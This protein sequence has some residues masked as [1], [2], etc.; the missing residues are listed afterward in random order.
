MQMARMS[1]KKWIDKAL[2]MGTEAALK[3]AYHRPY[4]PVIT[5]EARDWVIHSA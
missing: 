5:E 3:E 1:V 2:A 4:A